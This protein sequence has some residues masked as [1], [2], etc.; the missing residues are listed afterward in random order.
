MMACQ[1]TVLVGFSLLCA[2]LS[3]QGATSGECSGSQGYRRKTHSVDLLI[4]RVRMLEHALAHFHCEV[5]LIQ[6]MLVVCNGIAS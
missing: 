6:L 2:L 1:Y 5:L 4:V 3:C